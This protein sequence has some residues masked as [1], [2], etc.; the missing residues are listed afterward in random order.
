MPHIMVRMD[1]GLLSLWASVK[2]SRRASCLW[3]FCYQAAR[4][5]YWRLRYVQPLRCNGEKG[6]W[7][8]DLCDW[9]ETK[10]RAAE[11]RERK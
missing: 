6:G 4:V 3:R 11:D 10:A 5:G 2:H 9:L 7:R 8:T 1:K